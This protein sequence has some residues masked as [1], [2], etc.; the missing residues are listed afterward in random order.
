MKFREVQ[1]GGR[2]GKRELR[3]AFND[4]FFLSCSFHILFFSFA[5]FPHLVLK[6]E[7]QGEEG[8]VVPV[9]PYDRDS[10]SLPLPLTLCPSPHPPQS[11]LDPRCQL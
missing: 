3:S 8:S 11:I 4:D 9:S 2:E 6:G 10:P 5:P 7:T 1:D